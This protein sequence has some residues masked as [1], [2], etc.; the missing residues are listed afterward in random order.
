MNRACRRALKREQTAHDRALNDLR[1]CQQ[2]ARTPAGATA[3]ELAARQAAQAWAGEGFAAA[4]ADFQRSHRNLA[5]ALL[6]MLSQRATD[7]AQELLN[8]ADEYEPAAPLPKPD[9]TQAGEQ[10]LAARVSAKRD[11]ALLKHRCATRRAAQVGTVAQQAP[12]VVVS[13]SEQQHRLVLISPGVSPP[14]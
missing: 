2:R 3:A 9:Y 13:N 14:M 1:E 8:A 5:Q 6:P 10:L 11:R 12:P 4:V 7:T